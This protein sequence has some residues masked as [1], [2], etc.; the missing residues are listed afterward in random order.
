MISNSGYSLDGKVLEYFNVPPGSLMW[1]VRRAQRTVVFH[2]G[3][4]GLEN[5]LTPL[6]PRS[7]SLSEHNDI[8]QLIIENRGPTTR[9][10]LPLNGWYADEEPQPCGQG[11]FGLEP[12]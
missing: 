8:I 2:D 7:L 11:G 1:A 5:D 4:K 10:L 9:H 3:V 6:Y 12:L